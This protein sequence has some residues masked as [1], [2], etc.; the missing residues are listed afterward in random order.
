L[1]RYEASH[2]QFGLALDSAG[3]GLVLQQLEIR[4]NCRLEEVR[5]G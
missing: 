3:Q 4:T 5:K 2:E 1:D